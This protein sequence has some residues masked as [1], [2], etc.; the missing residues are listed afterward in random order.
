[1]VVGSTVSVRFTCNPIPTTVSISPVLPAGLSID[2]GGIS[3]SAESYLSNKTYTITFTNDH[4]S[5]IRWIPILVWGRITS[6]SYGLGDDDSAVS[7]MVGMRSALIA[8]ECNVDVKR[9]EST[10]LPAGLSIDA[11]TGAISGEA[12]TVTAEK[13]YFITAVNDVG[14]YDFVVRISVLAQL[15]ENMNN[16]IFVQFTKELTALV[17][18]QNYGNV[19]RDINNGLYE[20][21]S[22]RVND[23]RSTW[24]SYESCSWNPSSNK[25]QTRYYYSQ[26][27]TFLRIPLAGVY[28]FTINADD[29]MG[30]FFDD[31]TAPV[32]VIRTNTETKEFSVQLTPGL[33]KLGIIHVQKDGAHGVK[34][35]WLMSGLGI[36]RYT[37]I[38]TEYLFIADEP[39]QYLTYSS[40]DIVLRIGSQTIYYPRVSG[41]VN[42]W[43][44]SGTLPNGISMNEYGQLVGY[45]TEAT[46]RQRYTIYAE[47]KM[48][49]VE[50]NLYITV[51]ELRI[52]SMSPRIVTSYWKYNGEDV[53]NCGYCPDPESERYSHLFSQGIMKLEPN[54]S[55]PELNGVRPGLSDEYY[56]LYIAKYVGYIN[57]PA[58]GQY[59]IYLETYYSSAYLS[60]SGSAIA[61]YNYNCDALQRNNINMVLQSGPN[62][63]WLVWWRPR[64][65]NDAAV[66]M[67]LLWAGGPEQISLQE[68]P[69]ERFYHIPTRSFYYTHSIVTYTSQVK[70]DDNVPHLYL[71]T[72]DHTYKVTP[73]LP[74]GLNIDEDTGVISG[75]PAVSQS[76]KTEYTITATPKRAGGNS[77][78]TVI[79]IEIHTYTELPTLV[80]TLNGA[81]VNS[82]TGNINEPIETLTPSISVSGLRYSVN[83]AL[84]AG[85]TINTGTGVISGTPTEA[86]NGVAITISATQLGRP[87]TFTITFTINRCSNNGNY[88]EFFIHTEQAGVTAT[89]TDSN[90]EALQTWENLGQNRFVSY[91][92]CFEQDAEIT[93]NISSTAKLPPYYF[94]YG[95]GK[96]VKHYDYLN[97]G[98]SMRSIKVLPSSTGS[99]SIYY[100]SAGS[101]NSFMEYAYMIVRK[102]PTIE[103]NHAVRSY[104]LSGNLPTSVSFNTTTGEFEGEFT[105]VGTYSFVVTAVNSEGGSATASV[106]FVISSCPS[107]HASFYV[108]IYSGYNGR[109]IDLKL[110]RAEGRQNLLDYSGLILFKTHKWTF[111]TPAGSFLLTTGNS[112]WSDASYVTVALSQG[113]ELLYYRQTQSGNVEHS[114]SIENTIAPSS[115]WKYSD[116]YS[117]GWT[118]P[119]F[120]DA[121]W[122]TGSMGSFTTRAQ[123]TR[124]YRFTFST[125][126]DLDDIGIFVSAFTYDAGIVAYMNGERF[127]IRNLPEQF[128]QST[129]ATK[130]FS[131]IKSHT[132]SGPVTLLKQTNV[133]AVETHKASDSGYADPFSAFLELVPS[134]E[135]GCV[136]RTSNKM[137]TSSQVI[138]GGGNEGPLSLTDGDSG[139]QWRANVG[140][141]EGTWIRFMF[142]DDGSE[143]FNSYYVVS[144]NT[145]RESDPMSW[146]L[147]GTTDA[148]DSWTKIHT[149]SNSFFSES[150][151]RKSYYLGT[152]LVQSYDG[153][154]WQIT[155]HGSQTSVGNAYIAASDF[156]VQSCNMLACPSLS[157]WDACPIGSTVTQSCPQF[158]TGSRTRECHDMNGEPKW[159][160]D[161]GMNSCEMEEP[162]S[163]TLENTDV[164]AYVGFSIESYK[165]TC[166]GAGLSYEIYPT[167]KLPQGVIFNEVTGELAGVPRGD[168]EMEN[169]TI[170]IKC[171]N[172]KGDLRTQFTISSK[173]PRCMAIAGYATTGQ[174]LIAR[175]ECSSGAGY[176]S[177]LCTAGKNPSWS[178][179][180]EDHCE[181]VIYEEKEDD[182][183]IIVVSVIA[184]VIITIVFFICFYLRCI[185]G[186]MTKQ[187][188]A[189]ALGG[190]KHHR[191]QTNIGDEGSAVSSEGVR[192]DGGNGEVADVSAGVR[193]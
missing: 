193:L 142:N 83:P 175:R 192:V 100:G 25:G 16:G 147:Y 91:G 176:I 74:S 125:T 52:T 35:Q 191:P 92:A 120:S 133:L 164:V 117:A 180:E 49:R 40:N 43:S 110:R 177:R 12:T 166:L 32:E 168:V 183:A 106:S 143:Y 138:A 6:C 115:E 5:T 189:R 84:P 132:A 140:T 99:F 27:T 107:T 127:Y 31:F 70:I 116:T 151:L 33:H 51:A 190:P 62:S 47:N 134:D 15:Q 67:K 34:I 44:I 173:V 150:K 10:Q 112:T 90:N 188:H 104:S 131:D 13:P 178:A 8:P 46:P 179:E 82:V 167:D 171:G 18:P 128:S 169:T 114:F 11:T 148:G 184:L 75:T 119:S 1:M 172:D 185:K 105:T 4:G 149:V 24:C 41:T 113:Y 109:A 76:F 154:M 7:F 94:I 50:Y 108:S 80:Y 130:L 36:T 59:Q 81:T 30:I 98:R 89:V 56:D 103:N 123:T 161:P 42:K 72:L 37:D 48:G 102:V 85:V 144:S 45:P 86:M 19:W 97:T 129:L 165:V 187:K 118:S 22:T 96:A 162:T 3:G 153:Y 17:C 53:P 139:T 121:H 28:N 122:T 78:T 141:S 58:D 57:I 152:T 20:L 163:F 39:I 66:G 71:G 65:S 55:I 157:D 156:V 174:G 87:S 21:D 9:F 111:C 79:A 64:V 38:D 23:F 137:S 124:Y 77:Y 2:V 160:P 69:S 73:A 181:E 63:V 29:C 186:S 60:I 145:D 159:G 158:Y 95:E 14:S 88:M 126:A 54:M 136:K 26:I 155:K 93:F 135:T 101:K 61:M 170:H 146:E 68:V 182:T